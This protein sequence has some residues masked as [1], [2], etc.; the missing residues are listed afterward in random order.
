[1]EWLSKETT[2]LPQPKSIGVAKVARA[3]VTVASKSYSVHNYEA[4]GQC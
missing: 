4:A 1:M 2:H 3:D